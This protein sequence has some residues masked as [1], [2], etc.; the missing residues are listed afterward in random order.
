MYRL[1]MHQMR[2]KIDHLKS[3]FSQK[4]YAQANTDSIT[5]QQGKDLAAQQDALQRQ[6]Q[7]LASR[8]DTIHAFVRHTKK[9]LFDRTNLLL[10]HTNQS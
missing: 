3:Q 6:N 7:Q 8:Q 5:Q 2:C 1:Q 10:E 4:Q 9:V